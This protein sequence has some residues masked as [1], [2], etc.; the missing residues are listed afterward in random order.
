MIVNFIYTSK[1][2]FGNCS[3]LANINFASKVSHLFQSI[4]I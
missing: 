1:A 3:W 4:M 2:M